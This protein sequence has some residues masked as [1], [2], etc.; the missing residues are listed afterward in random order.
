MPPIIQNIIN[1]LHDMVL[2][3]SQSDLAL[4]VLAGCALAL[5]ALLF[6]M[7]K[8]DI[9]KILAGGRGDSS[10]YSQRM[11]YQV[12]RLSAGD[13]PL[14]R[15]LARGLFRDGD[16]KAPIVVENNDF[17]MLMRL[18][19]GLVFGM[20]A[21]IMVILLNADTYFLGLPIAGFLLPMLVAGMYNRMRR[22]KMLAALP[23]AAVRLRTRVGAEARIVEAFSKAAE[24]QKGPL[25]DEMR[26]ASR[27]MADDLPFDIMKQIDI[28]NNITFFGPLA[29]DLERASKRNK[30][31]MRNVFVGYMDR[32]LEADFVEKENKLGSL[33]TKVNT[34]MIPFLLFG[35]LLAAGST[36]LI[37]M[38]NG[39]GTGAGL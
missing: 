1:G 31:D 7:P 23:K 38:I 39:D 21:G 24:N 35:M 34:V 30:D 2:I 8:I 13:E 18:V 37:Q 16:A 17:L 33:L 15:R 25:W 4:L 19:F 5:L 36:L 29:G 14:K 3:M 11:I 6:F 26:W 20:I 22:G 10:A 27:Q 32:K 12:R 28:R 9:D